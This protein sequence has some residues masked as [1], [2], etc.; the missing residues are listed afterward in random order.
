[1]DYTISEIDAE[2]TSLKAQNTRPFLQ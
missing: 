2:V 1:L